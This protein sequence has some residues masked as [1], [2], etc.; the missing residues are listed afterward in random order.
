MGV[1]SLLGRRLDLPRTCR[2]TIEGSAP[3]H[4]ATPVKHT[5]CCLRARPS[6]ELG[7]THTGREHRRLEAVSE[8]QE[9]SQRRELLKSFTSF[10][11]KQSCNSTTPTWS[12]PSP[13]L[14]PAW[15]NTSSAQFFDIVYPTTSIG[16][17]V[18]NV[19]G[20]SVVIAFATISMAW[21]SSP[22]LRTKSSDAMMQHAAPS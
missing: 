3:V 19:D 7:H 6:Y 11:A 4:C 13:F 20:S 8:S 14:N 22:C 2:H 5:P 1:P 15:A 17:R 10:A 16:L 18:S 9:C 21:F 12:R